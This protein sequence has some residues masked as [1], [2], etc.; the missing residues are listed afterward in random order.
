[1]VIEDR[2][3]RNPWSVK[4][5]GSPDAVVF[6]P[7]GHR[8]YVALRNASALAVVDRFRRTELGRI[9]L[10]GPARTVRVDPWGYALFVRPAAEGAERDITWVVS[11]A[12]GHLLGHLR[13]DWDTDLPVGS[14][15]NTEPQAAAPR[16]R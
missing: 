10:P 4:L 7:S 1:M 5:R 3:P 8:L 14:V 2:D 11:E 13:T 6:S 16:R 9:S 15:S 12:N